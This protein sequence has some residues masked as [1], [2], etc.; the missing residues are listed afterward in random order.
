MVEVR[1][2]C[3]VTAQ[4]EDEAGVFAPM[5][6]HV[7]E[8]HAELGL[9]D[10]HV[11]DY[12][13]AAVRSGGPKP[14]LERVGTVEVR[15]LTP[16]RLEDYLRF[17]DRDAFA[18]NP[19]WA[20]CYC[21]CHVGD[22]AEGEWESRGAAE[23]RADIAGLIECGGVRGYLAYAD[24]EPAGW[25]N[26]APRSYFP[27]FQASEEY[28]VDDAERVGSIVCFVI[29]PHYRRHGIARKLLEAALDGFR[30][31]GLTV[32]EAYPARNAD[33]DGAAYH[34]PLEMYE[35]AGFRHFREMERQTI[36]RIN[37]VGG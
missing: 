7:D 9:S 29:A 21:M 15:P 30:G 25:V 27:G 26:A 6:A 1:C 35:A 19:A 22:W 31:E 18:D 14:R 32:A 13:A 8:A 10:R 5:R 23:N 12:I 17:F 36:V 3:G 2:L 24:G 11:R 16:E 34:G 20:A 37:L 33:S 4:G 28:R